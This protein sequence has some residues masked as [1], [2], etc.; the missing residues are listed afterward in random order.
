MKDVRITLEANFSPSLF[1]VFL[2][3]MIQTL[4]KQVSGLVQSVPIFIV[5]NCFKI[6]KSTAVVASWW[7]QSPPTS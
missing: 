1:I 7:R 2:H 3:L 5:L 4:Y 6:V